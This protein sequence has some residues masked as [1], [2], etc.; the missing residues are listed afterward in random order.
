MTEELNRRASDGS[1]LRTIG[2]NH[3]LVAGA[4]IASAIGVPAGL[5]LLGWLGSQLISLDK[6]AAVMSAEFHNLHALIQ[7]DFKLRDQRLDAIERKLFTGSF[8]GDDK[9]P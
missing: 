7:R 2:E 8:G 5:A 9:R 4:R 3:V 1:R 6:T